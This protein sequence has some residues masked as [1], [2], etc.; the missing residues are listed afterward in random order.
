MN[1]NLRLCWQI[2]R[3][4]YQIELGRL[5]QDRH[6]DTEEVVLIH[7]GGRIGCRGSQCHDGRCRC[8]RSTG[9]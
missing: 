1:Q 5:K 3:L 2:A 9:N 8:A 4:K 6:R 7:C